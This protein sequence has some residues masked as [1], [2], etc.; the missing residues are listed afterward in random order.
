MTVAAFLTDVLADMFL[1]IEPDIRVIGV[2]L[3]QHGKLG[4]PAAERLDSASYRKPPGLRFQISMTRDAATIRRGGELRRPA[5]LHMAGGARRVEGLRGLVNR[6][7]MTGRTPGI[8]RFASGG[9][10]RAMTGRTFVSEKRM[11]PS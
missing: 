8:R 4:M 7:V 11:R 2:A 1:M 10:S 5:M 6:S 3:A 9:Q